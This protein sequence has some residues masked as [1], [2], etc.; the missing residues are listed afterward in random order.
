VPLVGSGRSSSRN[1]CVWRHGVCLSLSHN[2]NSILCVCAYRE[3]FERYSTRILRIFICHTY[4][5]QCQGTCAVVV[6]GTRGR[7][8]A[9]LRGGGGCR[10]S[11]RTRGIY[12]RASDHAGSAGTRTSFHHWTQRG[13]QIR[14]CVR[15]SGP[16]RAS[17][18]AQR[19]ARGCV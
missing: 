14:G 2:V 10:A 9:W 13:A 4:R 8:G 3:R 15:G 17:I 19:T 6:C 7:R 1:A 12:A 11:E 18:G 5:R 16:P